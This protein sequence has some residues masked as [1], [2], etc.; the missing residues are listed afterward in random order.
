MLHVSIV[1]EASIWDL[2]E[3]VMEDLRIAVSTNCG[4]VNSDLKLSQER[5]RSLTPVNKCDLSHLSM[6]LVSRMLS[7]IRASGLLLLDDGI[8][9]RK[10]STD[11]CDDEGLLDEEADDEL[12]AEVP[13]ERWRAEL[14]RERRCLKGRAPKP[15]Q[16]EP[17]PRPKPEYSSRIDVAWR[18]PDFRG[19]DDKDDGC[20]TKPCDEKDKS[21]TV[22]YL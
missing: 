21:Q 13:A 14:S 19:E 18:S 22:G 1:L 2:L 15:L 3:S 16:I 9:Q 11:H 17:R 10:P 8:L 20:E 7:E 5:K 6:I 4:S 12:L